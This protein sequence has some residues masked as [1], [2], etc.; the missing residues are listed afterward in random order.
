MAF[1]PPG[2][3]TLRCEPEQRWRSPSLSSGL[4]RH[5]W[6]SARGRQHT[7]PERRAASERRFLPPTRIDDK[8]ALTEFSDASLARPRPLVRLGERQVDCLQDPLTFVHACLLSRRRSAYR[9]ELGSVSG[10]PDGFE[11]S[12]GF[13]KQPWEEN[14]QRVD[15]KAQRHRSFRRV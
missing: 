12:L 3:Q 4:P 14:I 1:R 15:R 6:R 9:R 10:E 5:S 11:P 7:R 2:G 13:R 8:L